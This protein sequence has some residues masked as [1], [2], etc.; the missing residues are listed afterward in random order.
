MASLD[1]YWENKLSHAWESDLGVPMHC[2]SEAEW[3]E[4]FEKAGLTNIKRWRSKQNGPWQG[5]LL[6]TGERK[7]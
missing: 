2:L 4:M 1:C 6:V 5:T 7:A 3:E